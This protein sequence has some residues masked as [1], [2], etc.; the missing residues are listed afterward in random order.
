MSFFQKF[1]FLL[2]LGVLTGVSFYSHVQAQDCGAGYG[3]SSCDTV[4]FVDTSTSQYEEAIEYV[5]QQGLVKGYEDNT[6]RPD[7]RMNRA[8]FTKVLIE[9]LTNTS[10][11]PSQKCFSDV[12]LDQWFAGY[13][14]FAKAEGLLN[15]YPDGTFRPANT[16]NVAEALKI[17]AGVFELSVRSL[18]EGEEWYEP[19]FE[20]FAEKNALPG[21][22]STPFAA[23]TRAEVAEMMMRLRE[24]ITDQPSL[25]ACDLVSGLCSRSGDFSDIADHPRADSIR[26]L[27]RRGMIDGYEDGSFRPWDPINR[28]EMMKLLVDVQGIPVSRESN[29]FS[30]VGREW[31]SGAVCTAKQQ[32]IVGGYPDGSFKPGDQ[33]TMVEALKM[34]LESY[35]VDLPSTS[36]EWFL[37]YVSFAHNNNLF[38]RFSY[39]PTKLMTRADLAWML[40]QLSLDQERLRLLKGVRD[41]R[42]LGCG[43]PR[44]AV[45]PTASVINGVRQTY[46]TDVP[47]SYDPNTPIALTFAWHG[48][49]NSNSRVR[50]YYKVYEAS[51]GGTIMV[52][53]AGVGPWNLNRDVV[54]FDQL[55]QELSEQYCVDMDRIYVIGHSLG[56]WFTNSLA[57]VRGDVIRA[58]GSLG[59]GTT[60][61]N[62]SGPVAAITMHNP[63]D[64]LSPFSDG[65]KAR[66]LHLAQNACRVATVP[67]T[68]PAKAN[69]VE[70]TE[71]A[72][73]Q[74]VVWCPHTEDYSWGDYYP[75]GWPRW[76]GQ[77]IWD[78]FASLEQNS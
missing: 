54:I 43:M 59:G 65:I 62:C 75:H 53:P 51:Q 74:P 5:Q 33:V 12:P 22:L 14:C 10:S 49:T 57:C 23:I 68:S 3:F 8:E 39:V 61:T 58:S 52:Y 55:L 48:R 34:A 25:T 77:E 41:S 46:I 27:A 50:S 38:S 36:G 17:M 29:C 40:H 70:Y 28:A 72:P 18:A 66:D 7:Q 44:P 24:G 67:Y 56:S 16:V 35:D 78:F 11:L 69:C 31:F 64:R 6:F 15:G 1:L 71:C 4:A 9:S 32:G 2:V 73:D 42:S 19:Y 47:N 13:V 60:Q 30:D 26:F 21:T 76:V 20:A 63:A 45:A 37:P